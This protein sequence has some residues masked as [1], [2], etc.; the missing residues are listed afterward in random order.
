MMFPVPSPNSGPCPCVRVYLRWKSW[1]PRLMARKGSRAMMKAEEPGVNRS[2][3]PAPICSVK[4]LAMPSLAV[5]GAR[6]RSTSWP[7][8]GTAAPTATATAAS[9]RAQG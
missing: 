9:D 5:L 2:P 8:A 6:V 3:R 1:R 7:R 4:D